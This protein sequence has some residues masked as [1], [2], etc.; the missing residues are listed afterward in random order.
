MCTRV[1]AWMHLHAYTHSSL[2]WKIKS[3]HVIESCGSNCPG[4]R[5]HFSDFLQTIRI[6]PFS[7]RCPPRLQ[8]CGCRTP[9][10]I[11]SSR[12]WERTLP[13]VTASRWAALSWG[14]LDSISPC[15]SSCK[16]CSSG[17]QGLREGPKP[18]IA[19]HLLPSPSMKKWKWSRSAVSDSW[20]PHGL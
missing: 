12:L 6:F 8:R 9:P 18:C 15:A 1:C 19:L 3:V 10:S 11:S 7:S 20:Q 17:S 4:E 16:A 5:V 2:L 13:T 14:T